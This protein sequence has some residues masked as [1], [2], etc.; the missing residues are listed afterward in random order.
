MGKGAATATV[1]ITGFVTLRD[2]L[3][4]AIKIKFKKGDAITCWGKSTGPSSVLV[5]EPPTQWC[6]ELWA[7][8][9]QT[10]S[11]PAPSCQNCGLALVGLWLQSQHLLTTGEGCGMLGWPTAMA[12]VQTAH[13]T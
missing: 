3:S 5:L 9:G 2:F 10:K 11:E 7:G 13:P 12:G 1:I 8:A 4:G 6:V